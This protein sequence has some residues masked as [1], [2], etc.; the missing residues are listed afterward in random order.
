MCSINEDHTLPDRL[1]S[2]KRLYSVCQ[3]SET[4]YIHK[5]SVYQN[6][7]N[8]TNIEPTNQRRNKED[9]CHT[10]CRTPSVSLGEN[11]TSSLRSFS[12]R[13]SLRFVASQTGVQKELTKSVRTSHV[14]CRLKSYHLGFLLAI[15]WTRTVVSGRMDQLYSSHQ[16]ADSVATHVEG[17]NR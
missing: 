7:V 1:E 16:L 13:D 10:S 12:V 11:H 15:C 9:H 14:F 4:E 6:S 8:G 2:S 5:Q 17:L 3:T